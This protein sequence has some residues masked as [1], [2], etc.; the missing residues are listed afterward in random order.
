MT[1]GA[2]GVAGQGSSQTPSLGRSCHPQ[3]RAGNS[4]PGSSCPALTPQKQDQRLVL[5]S[6]WGAGPRGTPGRAAST[7]GG[8]AQPPSAC[9]QPLLTLEGGAPP[10]AGA[11][12]E[13]RQEGAPL[14]LHG[15]G[16]PREGWRR[17]PRTEPRAGRGTPTVTSCC[18][19]ESL[20]YSMVGAGRAARTGGLARGWTRHGSGWPAGQGQRDGHPASR[21]WRRGSEARGAGAPG[22]GPAGSARAS[23]SLRSPSP[24]T[25]C[26]QQQTGARPH[27]S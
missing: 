2:P 12:R 11:R 20:T 24:S 7:P 18:C 1:S 3:P 8:P 25:R 26:I 6:P 10:A 22:A 19:T 4:T 23:S 16:S 17:G 9:C 13:R 21:A 27:P 15:G 14:S 5:P